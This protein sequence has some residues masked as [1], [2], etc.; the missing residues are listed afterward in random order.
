MGNLPPVGSWEWLMGKDYHP[1]S[2]KLETLTQ[3]ATCIPAQATPMETRISL[4]TLDASVNGTVNED[5]KTFKTQ[6]EAIQHMQKLSA[7]LE[8]ERLGKYCTLTVVR[9]SDDKWSIDLNYCPAYL[10]QNLANLSAADTL[11]EQFACLTRDLKGT[12]SD[13][14]CSFITSYIDGMEHPHCP[15]AYYLI[16]YNN[17]IYVNEVDNGRGGSH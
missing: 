2:T 9:K 3:F 12:Y 15:Q 4:Y 14:R 5:N 1:N 7:E 10:M 6:S 8:E 11:G 16:A 17:F 13:T